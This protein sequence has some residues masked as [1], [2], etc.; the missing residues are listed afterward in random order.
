[1]FTNLVANQWATNSVKGFTPRQRSARTP[2]GIAYAKCLPCRAQSKA[3]KSVVPIS[4][5]WRRSVHQL[6][7][8]CHVRMTTTVPLHRGYLV[9]DPC[10]C[11]CQ[12]DQ[13][14]HLCR[15]VASLHAEDH[16]LRSSTPAAG[17]F[18]T[19][20]PSCHRENA[21]VET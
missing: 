11:E 10:F 3:R 17:P 7:F 6:L 4:N 21:A 5:S 14:A 9:C 15:T 1:M 18:S 12:Y 8:W 2:S 13:A 16:S 19:G 20:M